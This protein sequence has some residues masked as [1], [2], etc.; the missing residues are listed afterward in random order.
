MNEFLAIHRH[1]FG[2]TAYPFKYDGNSPPLGGVIHECGINYEP[3]KDESITILP[4]YD[5]PQPV[6]SNSP[7]EYDAYE[8]TE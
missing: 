6:V 8:P 7:G 2:N 4:W 3:D 5:G 1:R